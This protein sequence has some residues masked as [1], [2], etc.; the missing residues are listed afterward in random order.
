MKRKI[1][2]PIQIGIGVGLGSLQLVATDQ[3][4]TDPNWKTWGNVI[5]GGIAL[6]I[7][8]FTKWTKGN[9]TL[10]KVVLCYGWTALLGGIINAVRPMIIV[11]A[12]TLRTPGGLRI[13][14]LTGRMAPV[15]AGEVISSGGTRNGYYTP[16]YYPSEV[17]RFYRRPASRAQGF[18]S[19]VTINPMA[20]IPTRIGYNEILF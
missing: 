20:A 4:V 12:A 14:G 3:L 7:T 10:N 16:T 1:P 2:E 6:G 9:K 19:D 18:A 15:S 8:Q 11:R 17:G 13:S 5:L